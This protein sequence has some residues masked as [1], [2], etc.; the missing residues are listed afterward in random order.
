MNGFVHKKV[1]TP[2]ITLIIAVACVSGTLLSTWVIINIT[3]STVQSDNAALYE[4][5]VR[6]AAFADKDEVHQLVSIDKTS[7][8]VTWN[9]TGDKVLV[10]SWHEYPDSFVKGTDV[11]FKWGAVWTFT[12]REIIEWYKQNKNTVTD[13]ELRLKQLIGFPEDK[14][15]THF[16]AFWVDPA[17]LVRP[18]YETD[19]TAQLDYSSVLNH[20]DFD[21]SFAEWFDANI[22]SSYFDGHYPWTR[23]GYSYDWADNGTEYGLTEFLIL[24]DSHGTVEFTLS[25]DEFVK[26][27]D[28]QANETE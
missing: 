1:F 26:W 19:I 7:D 8:M 2:L 23:L 17:D 20:D 4:A 13:W 3:N 22:I 18:A 10:L 15:R 6:D 12:D 28:E 16:S 11:T 9:S 24:K 5:A 27:L 21:E 25:N 14:N